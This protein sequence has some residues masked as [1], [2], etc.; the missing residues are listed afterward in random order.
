ML[1]C[2]QSYYMQYNTH[3]NV[4]QA[5]RIHGAVLT[6]NESLLLT[7]RSYSRQIGCVLRIRQDHPTV[8]PGRLRCSTSS[9]G[10]VCMR[11]L[12]RPATTR[13]SWVWLASL[14]ANACTDV[15]SLLVVEAHVPRADEGS[16][17]P[18]FI[19][20]SLLTDSASRTNP[21]PAASSA[22]REASTT[23]RPIPSPRINAAR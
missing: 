12:A 6:V 7:P 15:G 18:A 10:D 21:T 16:S 11:Q 14:W 23:S 13:T 9:Q 3:G 4:C 2:V 8:G 19:M 5:Y 17:V 20:T 22:H 1:V